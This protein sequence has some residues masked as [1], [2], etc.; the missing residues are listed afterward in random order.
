[1]MM[2]LWYKGTLVEY[3]NATEEWI[4]LFDEDGEQ[5]KLNSPMKIYA[6]CKVNHLIKLT[7]L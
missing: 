2:M 6:C 4:A 7:T 3:D 5:T 1:M